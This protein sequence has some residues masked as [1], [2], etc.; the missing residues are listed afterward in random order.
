MQTSEIRD[1][2]RFTFKGAP[3]FMTPDILDYGKRGVRLFEISTGRGLQGGPIYGVTVITVR[4]ERRH[5][6]SQCF[7]TLADATAYTKS[8]PRT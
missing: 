1:K 5:D 7:G 2:F 3:N 6:L 4:G 8:L